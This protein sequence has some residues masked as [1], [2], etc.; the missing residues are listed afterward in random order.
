MI[1]R[2]ITNLKDEHRSVNPIPKK[3]GF[4]RV[5]SRDSIVVGGVEMKLNVLLAYAWI[6]AFP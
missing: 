1:L 4:Y 5:V 6:D 3:F 2:W